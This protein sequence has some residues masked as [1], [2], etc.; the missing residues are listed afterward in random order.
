M[1][2]YNGKNEIKPGKFRV[3]WVGPFKIKEVGYN[4][5][6]KLWTLDGKEIPDAVNGS[7]LKIYHERNPPSSTN[8]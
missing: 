5:A 3:K 4:G 1:L 6:I 8:S 2:K 7:K